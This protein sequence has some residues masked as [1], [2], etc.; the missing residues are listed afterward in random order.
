MTAGGGDSPTVRDD[1]PQKWFDLSHH[2]VNGSRWQSEA[3]AIRSQRSGN[4]FGVGVIR[5]A[6]RS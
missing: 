6:E 3:L 4:R 2:L 1:H 5:D